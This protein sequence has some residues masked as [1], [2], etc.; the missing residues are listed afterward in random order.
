MA[1][2]ASTDVTS[3][4]FASNGELYVIVE[5]LKA[6]EDFETRIADLEAA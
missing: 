4:W 6:L 3:E 1:L 2:P 5:I